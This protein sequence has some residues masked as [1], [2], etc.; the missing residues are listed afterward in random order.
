M[1]MEELNNKKSVR[2]F[3]KNLP[4]KFLAIAALFLGALLM[5]GFITHEV[6]FEKDDVFDNRIIDIL[7]PYA[8]ESSIRVMRFFTFFGSGNFLLPAYILLTGYYAVKRKKVLAINIAL[9]AF[10]SY[11]LSFTAKRIFQRARPNL[12]LIEALKTYSFPSGHA[13]SSFI[14]CSIL[15]Y[16]LWRVR[17]HLLWK[18]TLSVFLFLFSITIG[19][20]RIILKMH[21]P[22]DVLAGFCLGFAWVILSFYI[23]NRMKRS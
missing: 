12:P 13:L 18:W 20:S 10:T 11:A 19:I 1:I 22:T 8:T 17:L 3:L 21:Y 15:I 23:L 14:F 6:L 16:L 9:I 4:L 7:S 5:F 2:S